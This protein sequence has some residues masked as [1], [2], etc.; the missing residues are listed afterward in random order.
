MTTDQEFQ[1]LK[2][3][4]SK[5]EEAVFVGKVMPKKTGEKSILD[6]LVELKGEGF[7]SQE[8]TP[9]DIFD[10]FAEEGYTYKRVRSL[11]DPLQKAV[12]QDIVKRKKVNELW[13]Y[14]A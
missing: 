5:L 4:I 9:K 8:R 1:E 12:K 11:T 13:V 6:L 3:R 7:F 10:K 2:E 14:Y